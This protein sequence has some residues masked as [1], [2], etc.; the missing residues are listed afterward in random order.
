MSKPQYEYQKLVD[1]MRPV[2]SGEKVIFP[3]LD[4]RAFTLIQ[5]L[6][7][8][9]EE[10]SRQH[11]VMKAIIEKFEQKKTLLYARIEELSEQASTAKFRNKNL[12]I[13]HQNNKVVIV[14]WLDKGI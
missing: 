6:N 12:G 8:I 1:T 9:G 14:E 3:L 10:V 13:R 7:E 2:D 11:R 5:E 4:D